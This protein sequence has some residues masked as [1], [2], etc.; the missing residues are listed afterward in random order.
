MKI[1]S[2]LQTLFSKSIL[3]VCISTI[4]LFFSSIQIERVDTF[5]YNVVFKGCHN[6]TNRFV[7]EG[8]QFRVS[9]KTNNL[10]SRKGFKINWQGKLNKSKF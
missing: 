1:A 2:K 3:S 8:K 10:V 4:H 5:P 7:A 6:H 9:F